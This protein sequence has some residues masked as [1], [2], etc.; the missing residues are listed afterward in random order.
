MSV[1]NGVVGTKK[2]ATIR[3]KKLGRKKKKKK[4]G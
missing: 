1:S 4:A 3:S 2:D